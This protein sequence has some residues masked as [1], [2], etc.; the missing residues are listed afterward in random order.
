MPGGVRQ[1]LPD[2]HARPVRERIHVPLNGIVE[3]HASGLDELQYGNGG[4]RLAHRV[5]HHRR[6]GIDGHLAADVRPTGGIFEEDTG[7]IHHEILDPGRLRCPG[8]CSQIRLD[9]R[10]AGRLAIIHGR[11]I[12]RR[13]EAQHEDGTH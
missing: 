7:G 2:S 8:E 4:H 13:G 10:S 3:P 11:P 1:Q 9:A 6:G 12:R 5:G